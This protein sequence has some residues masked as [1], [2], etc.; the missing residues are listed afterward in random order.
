MCVRGWKEETEEGHIA[1]ILNHTQ[2]QP[3]Q[4]KSW[5]EKTFD[6]KSST[7]TSLQREQINTQETE[8]LD[9]SQWLCKAFG[10]KGR[11]PT[12]PPFRTHTHTHFCIDQKIVQH[13][14]KL[15]QRVFTV[16]QTKQA[17]KRPN[18]TSTLKGSSFGE[19]HPPVSGTGQCGC[20]MFSN[21]YYR[22]LSRLHYF[23]ATMNSC[24]AKEK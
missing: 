24:K 11:Q 19:Q 22:T 2:R 16:S 1:C 18:M 3:E 15:M 14:L 17:T 4:N 20:N 10:K 7:L 13:A 12:L 8:P 21:V 5:K 6:D 23:T 9:S